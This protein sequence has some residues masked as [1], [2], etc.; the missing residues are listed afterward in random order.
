MVIPN[1]VVKLDYNPARDILSVEWPEVHD[2]SIA[3]AEYTLD[4]IVETVRCYDVKYLLT[5]VRKGIVDIPEPRYREM[6]L[7][8]AKGL[9][10]TRLQ[11][12]ARVVTEVTV[13]EE[14]INEVRQ[15]ARLVVPFRNFVDV[16]EALKWL[17]EK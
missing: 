7:R 2:Y 11:K 1:P 4:A 6:I 16:E 10:A 8:F 3:E 17:T 5:D 14:P 9:A 15:E 12:L 13:R